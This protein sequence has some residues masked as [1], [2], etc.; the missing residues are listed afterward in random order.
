MLTPVVC[1][2]MQ[3]PSGDGQRADDI[4]ELSLLLTSGQT[5]ALEDVARGRDLTV[6]QLLRK[7]VDGFLCQSEC[8]RSSG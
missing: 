4:V 7:V 2:R 1:P 8:G 5:A 3:E 6:G